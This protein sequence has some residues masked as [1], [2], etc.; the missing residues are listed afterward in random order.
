LNDGV[1][2]VS[3]PVPEAKKT[4]RQIT[5]EEGAKTKPAAA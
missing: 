3:V 5:V 4:V 2:K 1:L